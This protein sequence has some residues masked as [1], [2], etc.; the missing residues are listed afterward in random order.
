MYR[1]SNVDKIKLKRKIIQFWDV[2]M[3][4]YKKNNNNTN[5]L[6]DDYRDWMVGHVPLSSK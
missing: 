2:S 3:S 6:S 5:Y 1:V 4:K